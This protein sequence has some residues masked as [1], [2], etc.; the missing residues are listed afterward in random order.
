MINIER[1]KQMKT[2]LFYRYIYGGKISLEEYDTSDII[3]ILVA[4]GE[5][6]LQKLIT[7][8]Q[9]FLIQNKVNWMEQNFSLI[10]QTSSINDS[11]LE[12]QKFCTDLIS[13]KPEKIFESR[14]FISIPE[15]SMISLIQNDNLQ[16]HE[17]QVWKHVLKWGLAQNPELSSDS[18][19]LS[20][21]DL[22]ILKNTLQQCVP[23]I[24]FHNLTSKEFLYNVFPYR[25]IL[26]EELYIDL[27]KCFLDCDN[28]SNKSKPRATKKFSI[29]NID[30]NI[31]T[32][33][34]AELIS[35]WIDG[36]EIRAD[37]MKNLYEFKL[38]FRGSCDGFSPGYFHESCD[39]QSR[40][41]T[42]IK[43]KES[44]EI[45]GGYNPS[46]WDSDYNDDDE[47]D[48]CVGVNSNTEESF[49]FSFKDG[50]E[51]YILSCIEDNERA[52]FN[53]VN[54][55]PSFGYG[56]LDFYGNYGFCVNYSYEKPIRETDDEFLVEEYEV[57]QVVK[58]E[59]QN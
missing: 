42:I 39:N 47:C 49:I 2:S 52:I 44:D 26:P 48:E 40:T 23:F 28:K 16:M 30:S 9:S 56:D 36:S 45:L 57:F 50:I 33:Q 41:V 18:I 46:V 34:H 15:K 6:N 22:N 21:D 27:L 24:R 14:D 13:E 31:I 29:K 35:K 17:V 55:G 8:L 37:G 32:D 5:L 4:A 10:Y 54:R 25:E 3:K 58:I 43:V 11:F 12:L 38:I 7:Y 1:N 51:N 19:S 20:K 53:N 59:N